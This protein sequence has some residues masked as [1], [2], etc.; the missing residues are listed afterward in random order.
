MEKV[1]GN[2]KTGSPAVCDTTKPMEW[3]HD[4][5]GKQSN[6][7]DDNT[8]EESAE[9]SH[10]SNNE[11]YDSQNDNMSVLCSPPSKSSSSRKRRRVDI[12]YKELAE[13]LEVLKD[14][15]YIKQER[16]FIHRKFE[17]MMKAVAELIKVQNWSDEK[18]QEQTDDVY[19]K[20][21]GS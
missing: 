10:S 2:R 21:Y 12:K 7:D 8:D 14:D 20:T 6:G 1:M 5:D 18:V 15:L 3:I 17:N 9:N 16:K 19:N 13:E 4:K 11:E